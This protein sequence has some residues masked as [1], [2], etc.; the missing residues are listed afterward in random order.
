MDSVCDIHFSI[1][2]WFQIAILKHRIKKINSLSL[3]T[4]ILADFLFAFV[5]TKLVA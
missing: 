1:N 5:F 3:L 2:F 4:K